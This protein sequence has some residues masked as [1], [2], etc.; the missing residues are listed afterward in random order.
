MWASGGRRYEEMGVAEVQWQVVLAGATVDLDALEV[1]K[2]AQCRGY[3][4][5][6]TAQ[7]ATAHLGK[8]LAVLDELVD[9]LR[10]LE[11]EWK[12]ATDLLEKF[13]NGGD[14]GG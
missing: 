11:R 5:W 7:Y 6:L 14:D 4:E 8:D 10:K 1:S 3:V 2:L 13:E 9:F 12:R